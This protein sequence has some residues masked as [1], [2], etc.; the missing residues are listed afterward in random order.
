MPPA[1]KKVNLNKES[2]KEKVKDTEKKASTKPK[3]KAVSGADKKEHVS[4]ALKSAAEE[5]K[6]KVKSKKA[7]VWEPE[8]VE[9]PVVKKE[10]PRASIVQKKPEVPV[11]IEVK[12]EI[13]PEATPVTKTEIL[14]PAEK[15]PHKEPEV[16]PVSKPVSVPPAVH[17]KSVPVTPAKPI[18]EKHEKKIPVKQ[19]VKHTKPVVKETP[20]PAPAP[21]TVVVKPEE[22]KPVEITPVPAP[23]SVIEKKAPLIKIKINE[24]TTV[25]ELSEKMTKPVSEVMK[26]LLSMKI[27]ATINQRLDSD[28]AA[29]LASEFGYETQYAPLYSEE[30]DTT[31]EDKSKL[32]HRAPIVTV[33]GH[34]DHGKTT[35]LD[36]IRE[37]KVTEKEHGGITQH[38]GAY[39][40]KTPKGDIVFL[41]TPGHEAF[42]A[43]RAHGTKVTDIVVLVVAADDGI[44]PQTIEAIDH[45]RSA[46]VPIIV[47]VNKIDIAKANPQNVKQQL[48]SNG[49]LSDD[50]GGDT[51]TVEIS[52]RNNINIDKLIE[53]ILFKAELLDLKANPDKPAQGIIIEAQMHS[54]R[55]PVATVLVQTGTM[56]VGDAFVTGVT[57]GKIR[58]MIDEYGERV[59]TVGPSTPIEIL[60]FNSLPQLGDRFVIVKDERIAREIMEKRQNNVLRD[61]NVIRKKVS[62]EDLGTKIKK[63][64]IILKTDVQGSSEAIRD[65][66]SRISHENVEINI[67]HMG[68][69]AI[70]E[71]DINLAVASEAVIIAFNIR[72]DPKAEALAEREGIDIRIYRIIY[73]LIS[74]INKAL[75][76][77]LE[78]KMKEVIYGH[79][80]VKK[81]YLVSKVGTIA[82]CQV[83]NGKAK[84]LAKIRLLRDNIIVFDGNI[85]S[86]KRFKDDVKEVDKGYECGI[87]LENFNDIKTG[88]ILEFYGQE[89][90]NLGSLL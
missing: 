6:K 38:I 48:S 9:P 28:I 77:M 51:L 52:A 37:T 70:N 81:T 8:D 19:D 31:E 14:K 36:T 20:A 72:P 73:E 88:D 16:K 2:A 18:V 78:A 65:A 67:L 62:L 34:V 29:I 25:R 7:P 45:A 4:S 3:K 40:V 32:Q 43:M 66:L 42:T 68:V 82:G 11:V 55:G 58:A 89:K 84:R 85:A 13:Q 5:T 75:Q 41:D 44:M 79:V 39:R 50:W 74:D 53:T 69:G 61:K 33:M 90:V 76:G 21:A 10:G 59:T 26:K 24:L 47:A 83:T 22:I 17:P 30:A 35:L 49:L 71:S 57:S 60:G 23:I 87:L 64:N 46:N 27:L 54:Q 56:S 15:A 63:L 1:K 12:P 86:L 80:E